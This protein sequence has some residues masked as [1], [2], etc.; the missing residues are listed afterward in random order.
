MALMDD[1]NTRRQNEQKYNIDQNAK[2]GYL[3]RSRARYLYNVW[4]VEGYNNTLNQNPQYHREVLRPQNLIP[5]QTKVWA[6]LGDLIDIE[7][8]KDSALGMKLF[9][10]INPKLPLA[11]QIRNKYRNANNL[12]KEIAIIGPENNLISYSP[13]NELEAVAQ[14]AREPAP[15]I[16]SEAK[17]E[18][19]EDSIITKEPE[20]LL[21]PSTEPD[22]KDDETVTQKQEVPIIQATDSDFKDQ[23][24]VNQ[25]YQSYFSRKQ[26]SHNRMIVLGDRQKEILLAH[27]FDNHI[28]VIDGGPGTGKTSTM[29]QRLKL[30]ISNTFYTDPDYKAEDFSNGT[31][32]DHLKKI[33]N[34]FLKDKADKND[35]W[36]F[37]SPTIQLNEF[38]KNS[39]SGEGLKYIPESTKVWVNR[40]RKTLTGYC[41]ELAR[42]LYHFVDTTPLKAELENEFFQASPVTLYQ[43]FES[44]LLKQFKKDRFEAFEE[45]NRLQK[46]AGIERPKDTSYQPTSFESI[47][48]YS[49]SDCKNTFDD[50][51]TNSQASKNFVKQ[52]SEQLDIELYA[53]CSEEFPYDE[54]CSHF[55][56]NELTTSEIRRNKILSRIVL[57][58]FIEKN[59]RKLFDEIFNT[60]NDLLEQYK[61]LREL[62]YETRLSDFKKGACNTDTK[63]CNKKDQD[64]N[65]ET[66]DCIKV[67]YKEQFSD[68][69]NTTMNIFFDNL[70]QREGYPL[71][72]KAY[73][74][75]FT[76]TKG[77]IKRNGFDRKHGNIPWIRYFTENLEAELKRITEKLIWCIIKNYVNKDNKY[78]GSD[79][80]NSWFV[81]T[82]I[83]NEWANFKDVEKARKELYKKED[84]DILFSSTFRK[85]YDEFRKE[86]G[87]DGP[88]KIQ[89]L[90]FQIY[91]ANTLAKKLYKANRNAF[92]Q[93]VPRNYILNAYHTAARIIIGID[94]ST[95]FTPVELAAMASLGHPEYNCITLAGDQMQA[96]NE[97]GITN[98]SQLQNGIFFTPCA[99]MDL[100]ISYRQSH[101]LLEM[102]KK[103]YKRALGK[104]APYDSYVTLPRESAPL[105][106]RSNDNNEKIKWLAN[107][108]KSIQK[109]SG[110]QPAT[111]IFYPSDNKNEIEEFVENLSDYITV[112]SC[113]S[114]T[115]SKIIVYPLSL[116][117]GLE[118]EVAFFYDLDSINDTVMQQRYL[119]VGLSRATFY[120]GATSSNSWNDDLSKDFETDIQKANWPLAEGEKPLPPSNDDVKKVFVN[121]AKIESKKEEPPKAE[122]APYASLQNANKSSTTAS[123]NEE[124]RTIRGTIQLNQPNQISTTVF[125]DRNLQIKTKDWADQHGLK[126]DF[127]MRLL[128]D[129]GVPVRSHLTK[130]NVSEFD[131]I[132]K[133]AIA[134]KKK[135]E[136]RNNYLAR[137][138]EHTPVHSTVLPTDPSRLHSN[139]R[140]HHDKL[141]NGTITDRQD[142][143]N[144]AKISIRFDQDNRTRVFDL[145]KA[146][147]HL[148]I[149]EKFG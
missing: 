77:A 101:T 39:L 130:L 17:P 71:S 37:F 96:F 21:K 19:K 108:I 84:F 44:K 117:K 128:R 138:I 61:A 111:A 16:A 97:K 10:D 80:Q 148:Q 118:F 70:A 23:Y 49:A 136:E 93:L 30:L 22:T 4:L 43:N 60:D 12:F 81:T 102:A 34:G 143:N 85:I 106:L 55:K 87:F 110:Y 135:I 133:A 83:S 29:I 33:W 72:T 25:S 11:E 27:M 46:K 103:I 6:G 86:N 14:S 67:P 13:Q 134:E 8:T 62:L 42:D 50:I 94:E 115:D 107:R 40:S 9:K 28:L 68:A 146:L 32:L 7:L 147:P 45:L 120:L 65:S 88:Y 104:E 137:F 78:I 95:D 38:L 56:K 66:N 5:D 122:T 73:Q 142:T 69:T 3:Y 113:F 105:L 51:D 98:W 1:F 48:K 74:T 100:K 15:Q 109:T 116:V 125:V 24:S 26:I 140:I 75:F 144:D 114:T 47:F 119:Y 58:W 31:D 141:G 91:A 52:L 20:S 112:E 63:D 35:T 64:K 2:Q 54:K 82:K 132:E 36:M 131:K 90:S 145:S 139:V 57:F 41:I 99:I 121:E 79:F 18:F 149:I 124:K 59:N 92:N 76:A 53:A 126:V 123:K 127:V 89:E 129:A